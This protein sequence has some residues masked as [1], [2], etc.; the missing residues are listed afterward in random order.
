MGPRD[1]AERPSPAAPW[2]GDDPVMTDSRRQ[3]TPDA[4]IGIGAA[5]GAAF[6]L[7]L[8]MLLGDDLGMGIA[9]GVGIG[10][11]VG[12]IIDGAIERGFPTA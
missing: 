5:L 9:F 6:G 12:L 11:L 10:A 3:P 2:S 1:R 4:W 8:A 7:I